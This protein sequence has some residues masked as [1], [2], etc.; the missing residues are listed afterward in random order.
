MQNI[1]KNNNSFEKGGLLNS[2]PF[3][4]SHIFWLKA[5]LLNYS[6]PISYN[7]NQTK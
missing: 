4:T 6:N 1:Q 5:L 7:T 2:P 3:N